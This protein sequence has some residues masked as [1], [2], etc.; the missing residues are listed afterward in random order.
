MAGVALLSAP[1]ILLAVLF[2]RYMV[3]GL[4]AGSIK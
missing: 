3:G 2:G 1:L 4:T